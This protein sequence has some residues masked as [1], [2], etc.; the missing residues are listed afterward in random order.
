MGPAR[1]LA[2][3]KHN[4]TG[5]LTAALGVFHEGVIC[6]YNEGCMLYSNMPFKIVLRH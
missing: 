4:I 3:T 1:R 6:S 2:A 5:K